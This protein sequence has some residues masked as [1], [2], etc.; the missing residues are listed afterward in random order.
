MFLFQGRAANTKFYKLFIKIFTLLRSSR[1]DNISKIFDI[2]DDKQDQ[3][4]K[5]VFKK[6][7]KEKYFKALLFNF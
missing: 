3:L 1:D 2:F 4:N 6:V 5:I 7:G